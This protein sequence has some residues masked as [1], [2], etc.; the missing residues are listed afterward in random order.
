MG[1]QSF[2]IPNNAMKTNSELN[3]ATPAAAGRLYVKA[4]SSLNGAWCAKNET[5]VC[6]ILAEIA[7]SLI[8]YF[9]YYQNLSVVMQ[10]FFIGF[11]TKYLITLY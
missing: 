2:E 3:P 7:F 10:T 11:V 5:E 6:V 9:E 1:V 4:G 8:F